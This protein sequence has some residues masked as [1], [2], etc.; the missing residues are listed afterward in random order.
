MHDDLVQWGGAERV[1]AALS[2]I[3]PEAPIYTLVYDKDNKI[4]K[5]K[6]SGKKIVTS[7][8]QQIPGW[9]SLYKPSFFLH[10]IAFE[11]FDF[12]EFD[13][14]ISQTTRFAK[15]IVTKPETKHI[16]YCHTPPRFLWGFSGEKP[17]GVLGLLGYLRFLRNYDQITS[18]RVDC[19]VAGSKNAQE[20]IKEVYGLDSK[21]IFPFV[22]LERFAGVEVFDGGYLL[23]VAR[24]NS[25]KRV[26]LAVKSANKLQIPLKVVGTGPELGDL[27]KIAGPT[28]EFLERLDEQTLTL[29][30]SGCKA[31]VIA[32]EE[33]FGLMSLEAQVLGKPVIAF[34]RGGALETVIDGETGC[35]FDSQTVESLTEALQKLDENVY[36]LKRCLSQA[37]KFSKEKFTQEFRSLV[38]SL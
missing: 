33:D 21:V 5:D 30:L 18:R 35:L 37:Q 23:V 6:F 1:L 11:Q 20:R 16:C 26:D 25:Y 29:V 8:L 9:K 22:D 12:S 3:F 7:F 10:P 36:N 2:D 4:L 27:R 17:P 13:L 28:V 32:G 14:V 34:K 24:L 19:F 38:S 15:V 31:L